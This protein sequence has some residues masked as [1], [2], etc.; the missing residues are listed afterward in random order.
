MIRPRNV[1]RKVA[2]YVRY[3]LREI[4]FPSSLPD[5]PSVKAKR[6]RK[7][8][9]REHLQ[10]WR[11]ALRLYVESWR[12]GS[13]SFLDDEKDKSKASEESTKR[14]PSVV[15]EVAIAARL[16]AENARPALQRIYL[17]RAKAYKDA[18]KSFVQGYQE[19]VAEVMSQ[20]DSAPAESRKPGVS[21]PPKNGSSA[22]DTKGE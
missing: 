6:K 3:D 5:P 14:E 7:F 22:Q 20:N 15:E 12:G 21:T 19:G 13:L 2:N 11:I 16:G 17:T 9:A 1:F 8:T 18:L 4:V 10:V